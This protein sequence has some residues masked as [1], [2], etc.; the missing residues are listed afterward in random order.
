MLA[1]STDVNLALSLVLVAGV[2]SLWLGSRLGIPSILILLPAG[3]LV[4]PVLHLL[5]PDE[6]F[7]TLLFPT[8]SLGVGLL[9]FEGGLSLRFERTAE[10]R[11]VVLRLC[12]IGALIT[13][14]IGWFTAARLFDSRGIAAI[15]AAVLVVS[16]PTVVIPLLRL[17]QPRHSVAEVLRWEGIMID[18]VGATLAVVVLYAVIDDTSPSNAVLRI[19]T[20]LLVGGA[21][22]VVLGWLFVVALS[23]HLIPDHLQSPAAFTLAVASFA[24]ANDIQSEAG[25]MATTALG[26]LLANQHRA[27]V[28]HVFEFAENVS[29]IVLGGLFIVLGAR[30][31]LDALSSV[32]VRAL[33][34]T[35]V[36]VLIARPLSVLACTWGSGMSRNERIFLMC[37]APR[38]IVAAA[39]STV[40]ALEM[41]E[42]GVDP[43]SLAPTIM[44]VILATV[45]LYGFSAVPMAR[46]LRIARPP[47]RAIAIVGGSRWHRELAAAF[48][49]LGVSTI[50]FTD[51]APERRRARQQT[52][53]A[54]EGDLRSEE[55][56]EAA[57]ALGV[58]SVLVLSDRT[59]L[60]TAVVSRLGH[61]VGRANVFALEASE[62][63][64]TAGG[65]SAEIITRPA[66]GTLTSEEIDDIM[67]QGGEISIFDPRDS[68][69]GWQPGRGD[70]LL[71]TVDPE[72]LEVTFGSGDGVAIWARSP[73]S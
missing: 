14:L 29:F 41:A 68:Q 20:T 13:W 7:G 59:E 38:G 32:A 57:D 44:V 26:L 66:F 5:D 11:G 35:A 56:E 8:I 30:I 37:V 18:P 9:L 23:R 62:A 61:F 22:G 63:S 54:Y 33:I 34:L 47:R 6:Q 27:A 24:I 2:G 65:V 51:R 64:A 28:R 58:G 36:L 39:V 71:A 21:I 69:L 53:L 4:G 17:A 25:L 52:L 12:T 70:H 73:R 45:V 3:V 19:A 60:V 72:T 46:I 40:F 31:D 10:V 50:I 15:M 48:Q 55:P 16:G 42:A 1:V 67:S 49:E 43:G